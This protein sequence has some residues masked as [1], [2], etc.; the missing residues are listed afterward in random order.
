[1]L[2]GH[3]P[4][5]CSRF[6]LNIME[7]TFLHIWCMNSLRLPCTFIC[8]K[9]LVF[10][11]TPLNGSKYCMMWMVLPVRICGSVHSCC[12]STVSIYLAI[13]EHLG[14]YQ[15]WLPDHCTSTL[16][17]SHYLQHTQPTLEV[18]RDYHQCHLPWKLCI[19]GHKV[20][21]TFMLHFHSGIITWSLSMD[22]KLT[23]YK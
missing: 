12:L 19:S 3:L 15:E 21:W 8:L 18:I 4:E 5:A 2:A 11:Q 9:G 16:L 10:I 23:I 1:M 14:L 22:L 7:N 17:N 6:V 20:I 13:H